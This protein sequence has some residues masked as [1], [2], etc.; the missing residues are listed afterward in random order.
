MSDKNQNNDSSSDLN[1]EENKSGLLYEDV[2]PEVYEDVDQISVA[3]LLDIIWAGRFK[4]AIITFLLFCASIFHYVTAPEEYLAESRF[5]P[6][7]QVQQFQMDRMFA[8][9]EIARSLNIGGSQSDGSLPSYFYP[10]IIGSVD[11][12]YELLGREVD[13]LNDGRTITLFDYFTDVY[14]RPFRSRVYGTIRR[15][16]IGLPMRFF[17]FIVNLFSNSETQSGTIVDQSVSQSDDE[18][19]PLARHVVRNNR[20]IVLSPEFEMAS[21]EMNNRITINYGTLTIEVAARMPD[22]MAAVQVNGYVADMLQDYLINY[23]IE[24]ANQSLEYIELLYEESEERYEQTELELAQFIDSNV[25]QLTAVAEIER[26]KLRNRK[27]LAFSL[28]SSVS[29]RL[30]EARTQVKEDTPIYTTFQDP[31]FPKSPSGA[32]IIIL[33]ASIFI[34]I[35]IGIIW[36]FFEK[37]LIVIGRTFSWIKNFKIIGKE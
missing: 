26:D 31:I 27:D 6:E 11:F 13:L 7:R 32:N 15:N 1:Q 35:F 12:Q 18:V 20:V 17:G 36:I 3:D 34:G 10:D 4:I 23:R 33:P 22:P 21:S 8:F 2:P 19:S 5:L 37:L 30:E 28:Y 9:G 16:T 24:K 25:G 29:N 14:E